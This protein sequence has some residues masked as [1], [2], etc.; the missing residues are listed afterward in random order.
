MPFNYD[1]VKVAALWG[2]IKTLHATIAADV[3][4]L[5]TDLA[6][7]ESLRAQIAAPGVGGSHVAE[8]EKQQLSQLT[9]GY[10]PYVLAHQRLC[11]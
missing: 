4:T 7:M 3:A 1:P 10:A 2:Q 8:F 9:A 6:A 11:G 5:Q